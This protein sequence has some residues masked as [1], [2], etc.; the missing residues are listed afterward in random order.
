MDPVLVLY[1]SCTYPV[2][3][4]LFL[5]RVIRWLSRCLSPTM[6]GCF[7]NSCRQSVAEEAGGWD[8]KWFTERSVEIRA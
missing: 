7:G 4:W 6:V 2:L 8:Y 5:V 3:S 1:W